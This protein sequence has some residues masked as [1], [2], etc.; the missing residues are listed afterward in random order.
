MKCFAAFCRKQR[1]PHAF[2]GEAAS[3]VATKAYVDEAWEWHVRKHKE[4][5][6][7]SSLVEAYMSGKISV[8][9]TRNS[10]GTERTDAHQDAI[11]QAVLRICK[12]G[13]A[14]AVSNNVDN[15]DLVNTAED[16][17]EAEAK[18]RTKLYLRVKMIMMAHS[19][20]M[21]QQHPA[22]YVAAR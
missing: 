1:N 16:H 21:S 19:L 18:H 13:L 9:A 14:N 8:A 10:D 7:T 12:H 2:S 6:D 17:V 20:S 22:R 15:T 5:V 3:A 4:G 11:K